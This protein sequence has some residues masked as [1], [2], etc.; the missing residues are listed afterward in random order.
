MDDDS[1]EDGLSVRQLPSYGVSLV[2]PP[3]GELV[4]NNFMGNPLTSTPD[5]G[6]LFG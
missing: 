4:S 2:E 6:T 3:V 5:A 1:L